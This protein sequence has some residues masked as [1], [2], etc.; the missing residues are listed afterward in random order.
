MKLFD[1][2]QDEHRYNQFEVKCDY[3]GA[4]Y[5]VRVSGDVACRGLYRGPGTTVSVWRI[6][7]NESENNENGV[8]P[9]VKGFQG[10][11]SEAAL[12]RFLSKLTW[13]QGGAR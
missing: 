9:E 12:K 11:Y 5:L 4:R 6:S 13:N 1:R 10:P 2:K 8:I 7:L 3:K